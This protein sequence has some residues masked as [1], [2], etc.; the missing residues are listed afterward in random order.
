ML[1]LAAGL[2]DAG[3]GV[4]QLV[5]DYDI[6]PEQQFDLLRKIATIS[7]RPVSFTFMQVPHRPGDWR[8]HAGEF[9]SGKAGG[10][11][12]PRPGY[13]APDRRPARP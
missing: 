3:T 9:A 11:A 1:A 6:G 2:K 4:F 7:G 12:D 8:Q 13:P 10:A 5:P